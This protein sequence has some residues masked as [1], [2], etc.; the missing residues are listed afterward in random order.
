ME[1]S[2]KVQTDYWLRL[3][4]RPNE[5]ECGHG[6]TLPVTKQLHSVCGELSVDV[7]A[8]A[9]LFPVLVGTGVDDPEEALAGL[10]FASAPFVDAGS[11]G[12]GCCVAVEDGLG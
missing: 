3:L 2:E 9:G 1:E 11:G 6:A 7:L 8:S 5:D 10:A 12:M 4:R